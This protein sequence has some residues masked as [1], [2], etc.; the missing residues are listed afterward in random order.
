MSYTN[1]ELES[2]L[3]DTESDLSERKESL[4]G[5][6]PTKV[7][8]VICAFANDLPN[9]QKE[10]V[11]FVGAR[12]DGSPSGLSVTD[13]LLLQLADMKSDGNIVPPP[14]LTVQK[15][16]LAGAAMAVVSVTPA[17][18]PPVRFKGRIHVRVGARRGYATAQDERI[19]N[20]KRR[21]R[22]RTFDAHPLSAATIADLSRTRFE[23]EYLPAAVDRDILA[24]NDRS[25]E[26][27]LAATNNDRFSRPARSH[28]RGNSRVGHA[29]TR[30][31]AGSLRTV[32]ADQRE[33]FG[34][35]HCR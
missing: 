11:V 1:Q 7:P 3:A 27:R 34:R 19:L 16:M 13:E 8:E 18:A 21:F 30:F 6:A 4:G 29:A 26:Q 32:S 28:C 5:D 33:D 35:S 24:A 22:D 9:H 23:E 15:R 2:L 14:T 12:D 25:Y 20:E 10:G 17:D 31:V